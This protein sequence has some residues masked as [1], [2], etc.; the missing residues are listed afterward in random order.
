MQKVNDSSAPHGVCNLVYKDEQPLQ[1]QKSLM[2]ISLKVRSKLL[3]L[4]STI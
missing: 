2:Q 4:R 3:D 1:K